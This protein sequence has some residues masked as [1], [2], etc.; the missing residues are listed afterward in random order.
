M[1]PGPEIIEHAIEQMSEFSQQNPKSDAIAL[2]SCKAR[3]LALG[4]MVED[5]IS[6]IHKLWS[7]PLVGFFTFG[8]IGP[9]PQ[10]RCD[11]HNHTLV[12][13]LIQEK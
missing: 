10:G 2:F 13:V 3:Y 12:P 6:G 11:F 7:A 5:G 4:P 1:S 9:V 8:E